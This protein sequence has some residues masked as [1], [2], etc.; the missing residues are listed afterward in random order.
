ML[1][2]SRRVHEGVVRVGFRRHEAPQSP[3]P[4]Q[5]F[6][7]PERP[8]IIGIDNQHVRMPSLDTAAN[9]AC[10]RGRVL[11]LTGPVVDF[12]DVIDFVDREFPVFHFDQQNCHE[13]IIP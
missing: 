2:R 1:R 12:I 8:R 3:F 6:D 10:N 9:T 13:V 11:P 5:V 4:Y 7:K